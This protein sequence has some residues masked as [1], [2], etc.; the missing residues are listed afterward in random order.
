MAACRHCGGADHVDAACP[1]LQSSELDALSIRAPAA[2]HPAHK[3]FRDC[4]AQLR[5]AL[6]QREEDPARVW[7]E[8]M[9]L[10]ESASKL[11]AMVA[12][13]ATL[14]GDVARFHAKLEAELVTLTEEVD[15]AVLAPLYAW[16][17]LIRRRNRIDRA[18]V[19]ARGNVKASRAARR[20][21]TRAPRAE[22]ES[23]TQCEHA[24]KELARWT[25]AASAELP[26]A[27]MA[28]WQGGGWDSRRAEL[29]SDPKEVHRLGADALSI[30]GAVPPT[31]AVGRVAFPRSR[32][33][34]AAVAAAGV[35]AVGAAVLGAFAGSALLLVVAGL[36]G[37]VTAA[38][39]ALFFV[40]RARAEAEKRAA[41]AAVWAKIFASEQT[42]ALE[43]EVGWLDA[44][45]DAFRARRVFDEAK[46]EGRQIDDLRAWRPDLRD[47]VVEVAKQGDEASS[48]LEAD[49]ASSLAPVRADAP[50]NL[51]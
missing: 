31:R 51:G 23:A 3:P 47:F 42:V 25:S 1:L 19:T 11:P 5:L 7:L 12:G 6:S 37:V 9:S 4:R 46:S 17:D 50:Q 8:L 24:K 16:V 32:G 22:D 27:A 28:V 14:E 26:L 13:D 34:V 44:L 29:P 36:A 49:G 45:R 40:A 43:S 35:G 2:T 20:D 18:I 30:L 15:D 48:A 33:D 10:R 41:V 39:G 38:A 21:D